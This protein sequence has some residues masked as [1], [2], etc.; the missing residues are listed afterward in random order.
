[1]QLPQ[2]A[3]TFSYTKHRLLIALLLYASLV[4]SALTA[5]PLCAQSLPSDVAQT[6]RLV[7][8]L[9]RATEK[10][11][12]YRAVLTKQ[13]RIGGE[14]RDTENFRLKHRRSPECR[15]LLWL[16]GPNAGR[17]L[18]HC[19]NRDEGKMK[20]HEG[21]FLGL[22]TIWLDPLGKRARRDDLRPIIET[23]I[24]TVAAFVRD[25]REHHRKSGDVGVDLF[26]R[27]VH[28]QPSTCIVTPDGISL[29][30]SYASGRREVCMHDEL[31]LPTELLIWSEAGE[32]M[33]HYTF[34]DYQL[35]P[36]L[37]DADFNPG[38]PDYRF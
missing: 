37:T 17:E 13:Q 15:Y 29:S 3:N 31:S 16:K 23:G 38:N 1:M 22:V 27:V 8:Q 4:G 14:L 6:D 30:T 35:N 19:T 24:Y 33:E 18:L 26:R 9:L 10:V 11:R 21:G 34:R 7:T 2:R 5:L 12:D 36:G 28:D 25:D 32:L 20:V